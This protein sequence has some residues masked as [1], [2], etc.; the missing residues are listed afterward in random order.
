MAVSDEQIRSQILATLGKVD[1]VLDVGCGNCDLVRFLAQHVAK[2][3]VGIDITIE[4]VREQLSSK[5]GGEPRTVWCERVDAQ[6][7]Q[8]FSDNY[9]DAVVSAHALH[10]IADPQAA[11][12]EIRRVLKEGGRLFIADFTKGEVRWHED[13]YTPA[14]VRT[15]L[16]EAG[17]RS[18]Q[19]K[20][21][22]GEHFM[23]A[24]ALK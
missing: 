16:N 23:F 3:A 24:T 1:T 21:V 12:Q 8:T 6:H 4:P 17:F 15:M 20:K 9:F 10:E 7:M 5:H 18:V 19:V 13:Y 14:Q 2:E 22:P 11:L